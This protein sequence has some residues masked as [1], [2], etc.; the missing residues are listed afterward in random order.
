MCMVYTKA[1]ARSKQCSSLRCERGIQWWIGPTVRVPHQ[2]DLR[3]D[4]L[5]RSS[6]SP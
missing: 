4:D 5:L 2:D 3:L 1:T 6:F